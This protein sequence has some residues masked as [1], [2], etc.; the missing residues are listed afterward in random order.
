M[1]NYL[2]IAKASLN[3]GI[4]LAGLLITS[5]SIKKV[6]PSPKLA[7]IDSKLDHFAAEKD[8]YEVLFLG[9]SR[10]YRHLIPKTFDREMDAYGHELDSFNFGVYS[11]KFAESY[12]ILNKLLDLKPKNLQYIFMDYGWDFRVGADNWRTD[13]G[14]HHHTFARST[15]IFQSILKSQEDSVIRKAFLLFD[16]AVPLV[17]NYSNTGK[18]KELLQSWERF[19]SEVSA[20][21]PNSEQGYQEPDKDGYFPIEKEKDPSF[22][23]R[24]QKLLQEL[25]EYEQSKPKLS[26]IKTKTKQGLSKYEL[27]EIEK[28]TT[29]LEQQG[30]KI[31]WVNSPVV[32]GKTANRQFRLDNSYQDG[33]IQNLISFSDPEQYPTLFQFSKRFDWQ[34]LNQKGSEEFTKL[35]TKDF[36]KKLEQEEIK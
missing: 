24:R 10:M 11:M 8:E 26:K 21:K 18:L 3:I 17:Y 16:N 34:H 29:K 14:S 27:T 6:L 4:F 13:R 1:S 5:I 23:K 31:I 12:F 2:K 20:T 19:G 7:V 30:I 35:L 33:S 15:W 9:S 25:D 36:A 32:R 28:L 22:E